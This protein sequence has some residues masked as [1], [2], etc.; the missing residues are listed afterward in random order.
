MIT[1][2]PCYITRLLAMT[3]EGEKWLNLDTNIADQ[4]IWARG[5]FDVED[6]A[7]LRPEIIEMEPDLTDREQGIVSLKYGEKSHIRLAQEFS[8]DSFTSPEIDRIFSYGR[9]EQ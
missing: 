9:G 3:P 2:N 7:S 6:K 1:E 8:V 4:R 5:L